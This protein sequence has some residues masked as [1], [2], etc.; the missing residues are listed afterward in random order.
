MNIVMN[1]IA[2]GTSFVTIRLGVMRVSLSVTARTDAHTSTWSMS[3]ESVEQGIPKVARRW[4]A[5]GG[6][7][8]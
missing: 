7:S 1:I 4:F 8:R 5:V 3:A 6:T 2:R